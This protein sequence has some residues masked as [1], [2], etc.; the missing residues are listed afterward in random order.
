[1]ILA[2]IV[3]LLAMSFI[4]TTWIVYLNHTNFFANIK[5]NRQDIAN[6]ASINDNKW[7]YRKKTDNEIKYVNNQLSRDN[8][9][10]F[11]IKS[12]WPMK[13]ELIFNDYDRLSSPKGV[14]VY[15]YKKWANDAI[16][17]NVRIAIKQHN[18]SL[19]LWSNI[20]L[21]NTNVAW[22][23]KVDP[24]S[25]NKIVIRWNNVDHFLH[26][27]VYNAGNKWVVWELQKIQWNDVKILNIQ[28][29]TTKINKQEF[30][31]YYQWDWLNWIIILNWN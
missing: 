18:N 15:I 21:N 2:P 3:I 17:N 29:Q 13:Y 4:F 5:N 22:L 6:Q 7:I 12:N 31:N 30:E 20:N 28:R 19:G 25:N 1:M 23:Y 24:D 27:F 14:Y 16:L 8:T 9:F 10:S 26:F 11:E